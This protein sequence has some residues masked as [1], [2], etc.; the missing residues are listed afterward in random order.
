MDCPGK[1][2]NEKNTG[3]FRQMPLRGA[4]IN[5]IFHRDYYSPG[6]VQIHIFDNRAQVWNP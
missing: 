4:V 2:A 1:D 5:A 6:N 3:N